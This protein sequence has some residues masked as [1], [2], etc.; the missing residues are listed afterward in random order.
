MLIFHHGDHKKKKKNQWLQKDF[1]CLLMTSSSKR[2]RSY[3]LSPGLCPRCHK[4]ASSSKSCL[5]A[6]GTSRPCAASWPREHRAKSPTSP[7]CSA[8]SVRLILHKTPHITE[9]SVI[10]LYCVWHSALSLSAEENNCTAL[11]EEEMR[12]KLLEV[13][14]LRRD[15]EEL[16]TIMTQP[17]VLHWQG[18]SYRPCKMESM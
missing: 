13:A 15:I 5:C 14:Q 4:W 6:Y 10:I 17:S 16:R 1:F 12:I 7:C 3:W 18:S 8:S 9:Y 11:L 2:K